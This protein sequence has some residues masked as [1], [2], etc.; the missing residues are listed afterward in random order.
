MTNSIPTIESNKTEVFG[1][2]KINKQ[3]NNY[4]LPASN[5]N[6]ETIH[7]SYVA[8]NGQK[9]FITPDEARKTNNTT[10]IGLSIA[11]ATVLTAAVLF[12]LL[13]GGPKS[14]S[15]GLQDLK[16]YFEK[17][18]LE[19]NLN[20]G[21]SPNK[22][23]LYLYKSAEHAA[24]HTEAINNF[25]SFKD[26]LFKKIMGVTPLTAKLHSKITRTFEKIGRQAVVNSYQ[27]TA[28]KMRET[29]VLSESIANKLLG[30]NTYE[31]VEINGI[32]RTKAQWLSRIRELNA[33]IG[34]DYE[35]YFSSQALTPR[36]LSMKKVAQDLSDKFKDMRIFWST[37]SFTKFVAESEISA[38]KAT[39]S[40]TVQTY[41]NGLSYTIG[42]LS[43]NS[44]DLILDM[45]KLFGYKDSKNISKLAGIRA[46][47]QKY[48]NGSTKDTTL[49]QKIVN[50]ISS[51]HNEIDVALK[52]K[53]IKGETADELFAK[54]NE[55]RSSIDDF[56]EGKVQQI[57]TIYKKLLPE[58][59][60]ELVEKSYKTSME[61]L[62]KSIGV[63]TNDFL[64][65]LRDLT[66]GSAPTDLLTILGSFSVLGY[67]LGKSKD[68]DQRQS[69]ALKYGFPALAGIGVSL[70]CN[71][72]LFAGSK[73]L[74]IGATSTWIL[75]RIGV[76]GDNK[77]KLF[78][79]SKNDTK[80]A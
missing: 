19:S 43:R 66:L 28:G 65:K 15:K 60:Y 36:Y 58:K 78:K 5:N 4:W 10:V 67:H 35:K 32:K 20:T 62:D 31:V 75:N 11:G 74:L 7:D 41:R 48:L 80:K 73:S 9:I 55:L 34:A 50:E 22:I 14:V 59:D 8:T 21:A 42:D 16:I 61:S 3:P 64:S 76:W 40:K 51:L 6:R 70:Y 27:A 29:S 24:K 12:F 26:M 37:D 72:K 23:L 53:Q 71:A 1:N 57:L 63:E 44:N 47:I 79:Q 45:V 77:L 68:K 56:K 69:I 54:L 38:Q 33:E 17:L 52:N 2:F 13:K 46:Y 25:T 18:L 39:I 49:K 30:G